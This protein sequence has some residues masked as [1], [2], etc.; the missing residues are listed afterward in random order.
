MGY[1]EPSHPSEGKKTTTQVE[2]VINRKVRF[3]ELAKP[4]GDV[5][6]PCQVMGYNRESFAVLSSCMK[7]TVK[8]H[9]PKGTG[10]NR[11]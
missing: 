3:G 4:L 6:W 2:K 9:G 11:F 8:R 5:S 1:L 7:M 10:R